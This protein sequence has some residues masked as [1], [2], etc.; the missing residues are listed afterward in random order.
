MKN[1]FSGMTK[2]KYKQLYSLQDKI[3]SVVFWGEEINNHS[4]YLT[5]GTAL[6]RFF[7]PVR[8]SDD[9][10]FFSCAGNV[11]REETNY[12]IEQF[13]KAGFVIEFQVNSRDFVRMAVVVDSA[14]APVR[15]DFVND[16]VYREGKSIIK[17]GIRLDNLANISSNKITAIISRDNPKD[18]VDLIT[19]ARE[20]NNWMEMIATAQKK[21]NFEIAF[22]IK[23]LESFPVEWLCRCDFLQK[24]LLVLYQ[25]IL[26]DVVKDIKHVIR[27]EKHVNTNKK[28]NFS[29]EF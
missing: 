20:K 16:R 25:A 15:V 17:S 3:L 21:E 5:G 23:R 1:S 27:P 9:L 29:P 22:L 4:F 10:D 14:T 6:N 7:Y 12:L 19:L 2:D 24:D 26:P 28:N 18:V 13:R 11:F 8:Y